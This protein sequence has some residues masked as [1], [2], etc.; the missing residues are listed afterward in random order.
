MLSKKLLEYL[1]TNKTTIFITLLL[2]FIIGLNIKPGFIIMGLD[3]ASPWFGAEYLTNLIRQA[4]SFIEFG[5]LIFSPFLWLGYIFNIEPWAISQLV[6]W[7]SLISGIAGFYCLFPPKS[8][9]KIIGTLLVLGSLATIWIF[10]QPT[11]LFLH[12]FAGIPWAILLL[13]RNKYTKLEIIGVI[14]GTLA[15][16]VTIINPVAFFFYLLIVILI[17]SQISTPIL[18]S[19]IV[20]FIV[21]ILLLWQI[22]ISVFKEPTRL[23]PIDVHIYITQQLQSANNTIATE[24]LRSAEINNNSF[25]NVARFAT[26]WMELNDINKNRLFEFK[27]LFQ[28]NIPLVSITLIPVLYALYVSLRKGSSNKI[29]LITIFAIATLLSSTYFLIIIGNIPL[30]QSILRWPS[31]K[32]WPALTIPI[33]IIL[34]ESLADFFDK[35]MQTKHITLIRVLIITLLIIPLFPWLYK[36]TFP[37]NLTYVQMPTDYYQL[38]SLPRN[39]NL[40]ILPEP[41]TAFFRYYSWGYYGTDFVKYLTFANVIDGT[42]TIET[43]DDSYVSNISTMNQGENFLIVDKTVPTDIEYELKF[44]KLQTILDTESFTLYTIQNVE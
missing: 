36:D 18:K 29:G 30:L 33:W 28:N 10:S 37:N 13:I 11:Y 17:A 35:S 42:R 4:P 44:Q 40:I 20:V 24:N 38:K 25:V 14:I 15:F 2:G 16:C 34:T 8:G 7:G 22:G 5:P 39:S 43:T 21:F 9:A 41:Q 26:G 32:F 31:S 1:K 27:L 12:S 3:N 6:Y 23:L 19:R